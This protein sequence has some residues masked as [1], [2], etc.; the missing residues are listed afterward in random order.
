GA[1]GSATVHVATNGHGAFNISNQKTWVDAAITIGT[2]GTNQVG[3]AHTF[4]VTVSKDSGSGL[5]PPSRLTLASAVSGLAGA[6]ITR[7]TCTTTTTDASGQCTIIRNTNVT[8]SAYATLFR[9]GA[10][11]SAA[12]HVA[13]N[14]HGA[15]NISNQKTW[16]DA[17]ITI[18]TS[19]TNQVGTAH[20]FAVTVNKDS[21]SGFGPASGVTVSSSISA[22]AG[23]AITGGTCTTTTTDASGQCTI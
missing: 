22:L 2:S 9:S 12:V 17:Q 16:V 20:T 5:V 15:F 19:G 11:G 8:G 18:G 3:T 21:G 4:T 23:A 10:V 1:V 13:T 14:G 6:L 7:G